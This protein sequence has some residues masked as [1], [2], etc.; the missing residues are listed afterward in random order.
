MLKV[1]IGRSE[2][3][4]KTG[5]CQ[6]L[7]DEK[8]IAKDVL[9]AL[10]TVY[11]AIK[12]EFGPGYLMAFREYLTLAV[13]DPSSPVWNTNPTGGQKVVFRSPDGRGQKG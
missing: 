2:N 12:G 11:A 7:G 8:E 10:G 5:S 1:E 3:G 13:L 6:L 4:R 9:D